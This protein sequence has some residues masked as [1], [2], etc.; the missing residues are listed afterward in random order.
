MTQTVGE[1]TRDEARAGAGPMALHDLRAAVD[2]L[3]LKACVPVEG[4]LR[5][6]AM[7]RVVDLA[8]FYVTW[9]LLGGFE[10]LHALGM[11]RSML[12]RKVKQFK[13]TFGEHPD[14]YEFPGVHLRVD[15]YLEAAFGDERRSMPYV[16]TAG[17]GGPARLPR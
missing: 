11:Q 3:A 13:E 16:L 9:H 6:A 12:Y 7:N 4:P 8:G 15:E 5:T 2:R 1:E 10:G 17:E 14:S